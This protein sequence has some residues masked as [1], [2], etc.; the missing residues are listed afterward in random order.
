MT[1]K[2]TDDNSFSFF[3]GQDVNVKFL[4]PFNRYSPPSGCGDT[5]REGGVR[6]EQRAY[7]VAG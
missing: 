7:T 2:M 6:K 4:F 1:I 5:E 3:S